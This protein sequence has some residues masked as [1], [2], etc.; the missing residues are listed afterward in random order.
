MSDLDSTTCKAC[1][2]QIFAAPGEDVDRLF[3]SHV[4]DEHADEAPESVL[5]EAR[6][7]VDMARF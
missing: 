6:K 1:G 3:A 2:T 4:L 5:E 7:I